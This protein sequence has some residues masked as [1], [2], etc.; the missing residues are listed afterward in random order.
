MTECRYVV[1][2]PARNESTFIDKTLNSMIRQTVLPELW[3]IVNDGSTDDT[4]EKVRPYLAEHPW[5]RLVNLPVRQ[6]RDFAAKVNA[7]NA[8]K[9]IV[10]DIDYSIIGN[11]DGD[12]S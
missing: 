5:I 8:G 2:T 11:L 1:I 10:D 7:F 9:N 4:A 12:V 6:E 3:V